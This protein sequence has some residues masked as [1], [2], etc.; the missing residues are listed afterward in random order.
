MAAG[1]EGGGS[2][3]ATFGGGAAGTPEA[4]PLEQLLQTPDCSVE[5]L[6]DEED[7]IQEFK[8]GN[9]LLVSR[10]CEPDA[11]KELMAF[12]TCEPPPDASR[13]RSFRYP[14]VAV[15]LIT[16]GP[17][18]FSEA[19]VSSESPEAMELLWSFLANSPP[20]EVNPVLAGYFARTA[21]TLLAKYPTEVI[22]YLQRHGPDK[23]LE[24]FLDRIHLRSLAELLARLLCAEDSSQMV[25][26]TTDLVSRLLARWQ[27]QGAGSEAQENITLII[28]ELLNQKDSLCW[29]EDLTHQLTAAST[30]N[31]L[32][33]N[34]F[35]QQPPAVPAATSLLTTVILHTTSG[36]QEGTSVCAS[37]PTLSPLSP[38]S[39]VLGGED[40]VVNVGLDEPIVDEVA[41]ARQN[42]PPASPAKSGKHTNS[43]WLERRRSSLMREVASHLPRLREVLDSSL[44][45]APSAN[46]LEMPQGSICAVGGLILEVVNLI[47]TLSRTGLEVIL[48]AVLTNQLLP[49][50]IDVFF[51]HPWSSLLHN[52][53]SQLVSEVLMNS[54]GCR[55]DL[56]RQLLQEACFADRLVQEFSAEADLKASETKQKHARV[57]YMGHLYQMGC[58]L[59]DFES[60]EVREIMS[61]T[62]GWNTVV[63][64]ALEAIHRIHDEQL[65]GG[66]PM[67]D[68]GLASSNVDM[69]SHHASGSV[70]QND[71]DDDDDDDSPQAGAHHDDFVLDDPKDFEEG[72]FSSSTIQ[73]R[74]DF[75]DDDD[76]EDDL[77]FM[78]HRRD[79]DTVQDA[80]DPNGGFGSSGD[81]VAS[82]P[83]AGGSWADFASFEP[84][85]PQTFGSEATEKDTV[86]PF[87]AFPDAPVATV[88]SGSES[89]CSTPAQPSSPSDNRSMP[90]QPS[91]PASWVAQF[92]APA[93]DEPSS[94]S[95]GSFWTGGNAA[96]ESKQ[97]EAER[98]SSEGSARTGYPPTSAPPA[99]PIHT[100]SGSSSG[101]SSRSG[102]VETA[103]PPVSSASTVATKASSS[104]P[105]APATSSAF[106]AIP[107]TPSA[108]S[109]K[110][111][112][113]PKAA[114]APGQQAQA[115]VPQSSSPASETLGAENLFALLGGGVPTPGPSQPPKRPT[116]PSG[117]VA[118]ATQERA[119]VGVLQWPTLQQA[120]PPAPPWC[121]MPQQGNFSAMSP[122]QKSQPTQQTKTVAG[123]RG[124]PDPR[125]MQMQSPAFSA[126]SPSGD[127]QR[128]DR[129][130]VADFDPLAAAGGPPPGQPAGQP[131]S[132]S[133]DLTFLDFQW[134]SPQQG[135]STAPFR[136]S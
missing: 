106:T 16:C 24:E 125:Q 77:G 21:A 85:V 104:L 112:P 8:G 57:G 118:T 13:S 27:E 12:I 135:A 50:C 116:V 3:W 48:E 130:W 43:E 111:A 75:D 94:A 17:P 73:S 92:D 39:P 63:L 89:Q 42:S 80:F 126:A 25:F 38:P 115:S 83:A 76:E 46:G 88:T 91:P 64:P 127:S 129:S 86:A 97:Q 53:V 19:L 133:S 69:N 49:R 32:V 1:D 33:D 52:A 59:R 119:T 40:D 37:T 71:F 70:G 103:W 113:T 45:Q 54:E 82:V 84:V 132:P 134:Q 60:A 120:S 20:S 14:F 5:A 11:T 67:S 131:A 99:H 7:V 68:R 47:S 9:E 110:P 136:M 15:E 56:V 128:G 79:A 30:V 102:F 123:H 51:R 107:V 10:L 95:A 122:T 124:V 109:S 62:T 96:S 18:Q 4:T 34:I 35:M 61:S 87:A 121:A 81:G 74:K 114:P 55:A 105:A 41:P 2:F 36:C 28:A 65:G 23:L 93:F 78:V 98:P 22:A 6:L 108:A 44:S 29:I 26:R 31:F 90:K 101:S 66:I 58:E 117:A 100:A 72:R